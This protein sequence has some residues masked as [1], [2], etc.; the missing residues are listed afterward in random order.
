MVRY[1]KPDWYGKKT[2][3]AANAEAEEE[4]V[5]SEQ[6]QDFLRQAGL[7]VLDH[8]HRKRPSDPRMRTEQHKGPGAGGAP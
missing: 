6:S 3:E 4:Q 8:E 2:L 1:Q 5:E 7:R